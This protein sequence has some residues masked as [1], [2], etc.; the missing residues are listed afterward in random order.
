MYLM[1]LL[2]IVIWF[3]F[4]SAIQTEGD[5]IRNVVFLKIITRLLLSRSFDKLSTPFTSRQYLLMLCFLTGTSAMSKL[6]PYGSHRAPKTTTGFQASVMNDKLVFAPFF[7]IITKDEE[8]VEVH[9]EVAG[10]VTGED[11]V[12]VDPLSSSFLF[13]TKLKSITSVT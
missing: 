3:F 4:S 8:T 12:G 5:S 7:R 13:A 10:G 9:Q 2:I 11:S 1:L 6:F